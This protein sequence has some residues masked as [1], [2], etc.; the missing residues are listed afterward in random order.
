MSTNTDATNRLPNT[1]SGFTLIE[2]LV[3]IAIM[4][5]VAS[6]VLLQAPNSK[7]SFTLLNDAYQIALLTREA[8]SYGSSVREG[9]TPG[10]FDVGYGIYLDSGDSDSI[11]L[12]NDVDKDMAYSSSNDLVVS[13][14]RL[15]DNNVITQFCGVSSGG[16][17]CSGGSLDNL[18]IT[19]VRPDPDAN[20]WGDDGSDEY[21]N[22]TI[23]I[24]APEG[25]ARTITIYTTGQISITE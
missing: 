6:I 19:F 14:L 15:T 10:E 9:Q 11:I 2:L 5:I 8:Q 23:D 18:S 17:L 22:A 25:H 4:V 12:F 1:Q 21:E 13:T 3:V 7:S 16:T 24:E 20:I